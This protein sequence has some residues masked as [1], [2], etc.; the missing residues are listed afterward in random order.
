MDTPRPAALLGG[1]LLLFASSHVVQA[2]SVSL[3]AVENTPFGTPNHSM[4]VRIKDPVSLTARAGPFRVS[5]LTTQETDLVAWCIELVQ[6]FSVASTTYTTGLDLVDAE[7]VDLLDRLFTQ[8]FPQVADP[9]TGAAMQVAIWEIV[10]ETDRTGAGML[11]LNVHSDTFRVKV[12]KPTA[13]ANSWLDAIG[14][15]DTAGGFVFDFFASDSAQ[16]LMIARA[17]PLDTVP[18]PAAAWMLMT[19]VGGLALRRRAGRAV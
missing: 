13:L 16:D 2:G 6:S 3:E 10:T 5:N 9:L 1:A 7:R 17:R 19:A 11:E 18:L 15:D 12:G 14:R 8:Y 4:T